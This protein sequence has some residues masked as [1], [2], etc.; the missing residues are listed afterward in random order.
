MCG[1]S[2]LTIGS[3]Q[4]LPGRSLREACHP[5]TRLGAWTVLLKFSGGNGTTGQYSSSA[6]H[7]DTFF[8]PVPSLAHQSP[9]PG[10]IKKDR[11]LLFSASG[12][13]GSSCTYTACH[14]TLH[15]GG[16]MRKAKHEKA[17]AYFP[18][19]ITLSQ[20]VEKGLTVPGRLAIVRYLLTHQISTSK[21]SSSPSSDIQLSVFSHFFQ[22]PKGRSGVGG[23]QN[24]KNEI[25]I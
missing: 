6:V 17:G 11:S 23:Q 20:E 7:S 15:Q 10:L 18:L 19:L 24:N 9:C 13:Q 16:S 2:G 1:F 14:L 22:F 4:V 5:H 8:T 3:Y 12:W 25:K 21:R